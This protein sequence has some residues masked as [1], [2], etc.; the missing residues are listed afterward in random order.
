MLYM[1]S[2]VALGC[3]AKTSSENPVTVSGYRREIMKRCIPSSGQEIPVVGLGTWRTFDVGSSNAKRNV[4]KDVI[5]NLVE[6]GGSTID[7]SPMYGSSESVVGDLSGELKLRPELFLATKVWTTGKTE[8]ID[9]MNSSLNKMGAGSI[10]L[11]QVHNLVDVETHLTT[12]YEWKA[13]GRIKY[14]GI[15]HYVASAYPEMM[16]LMKGGKLDF[17]QCNY[18]IEAREAEDHLLP[19]AKEK[20]IAVI[21]NRPF[22][23]GALFGEVSGKTLPAWAHEYDIKTWAQFF[24]KYILSNTAVTCVIPGTSNPAHMSENLGAAVGK[25]PDEKGRKRMVDHFRSI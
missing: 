9:Q 24:L 7:S 5:K 8:G 11:M 19:L 23:E 6:G 12:L 20:G 13:K 4:R 18:N 25:L 1:S 21:I 3:L 16:R 15:T 22:Q 17:I 10:D 14:I 2:L